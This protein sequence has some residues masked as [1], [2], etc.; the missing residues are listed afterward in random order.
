MY[1]AD[2]A[3]VRQ[4]EPARQL[5][6]VP[7]IDLG[8]AE[9][10]DRRAGRHR[11]G[12]R[13]S[14]IATRSS[15]SARMS[16]RTRRACSTICARCRKR[17]V[18]IVTFNP[19]K[20]R[21][22]E[23]F[24]DPQS[25]I[26]MATLERDHDLDAISSGKGGRRHRR[27]DGRSPSSSS[28]GTTRRRRRASRRCSTMPSS[29][30]TPRASRTS[31]PRSAPP[32]GTRSSD[33]SG[34]RK[35]ELEAVG[36]DL[37]QGQGGDGDLRH[38]PHPA[39]QGRRERP[40]DR[41]PAADARQHRQARRGADAGARPFQRAGPAH[42]RHHREDR[43]GPGRQD[44]GAIRLHRAARE[45]A[46]H[47]RELPRRDR[48][49]VK[50][51]VALGGNFLRAVPETG[52][53]GGGVAAARPVGADRDQAQPQ[54][55]VSRARSPICC[56]ASAGSSSDVQASGPQA[57]SMEDSTSCIHGSRGKAK[58]A[59]EHLLS[60]PAIVAAIAKQIL[61][62]NPKVDW[63]AW[64]ADYSRDPR[65]DRGDV[66]RAVQGLQPAAVHSPAASGRATRRPNASG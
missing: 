60:E 17:G 59:S 13:I 12:S 28:N 27:D 42:R 39:R 43:T 10:G 23:R 61:P 31:S 25:P 33:E 7:R 65:R 9:G 11:P 24:T 32:T 51:F 37:R 52:G 49:Q 41:Q 45:G 35:R 40:H 58:P 46:R 2:G 6:H 47:G 26:E 15:S 48:R 16:A 18:E 34:L 29:R 54:P 22:L 53:D 55:P 66:S 63:D 14:S 5:Q 8:R 36:A 50:A 3:D 56:P 62:P 30:R 57:V 1:G 21:G 4:P 64:V 19:L 38:G 20:E 44:R